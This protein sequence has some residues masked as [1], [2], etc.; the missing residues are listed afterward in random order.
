MKRRRQKIKNR[1]NKN[2]EKAGALKKKLFIAGGSVLG[3][4]TAG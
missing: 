4:L 1:K 2:T 3:F